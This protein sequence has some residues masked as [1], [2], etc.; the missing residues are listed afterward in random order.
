MTRPQSSL[1]PAARDAV[2]LTSSR[3]P[4][5]LCTPVRAGRGQPGPVAAREIGVPSVAGRGLPGNPRAHW[6]LPV[7]LPGKETAP[8]RAVV[9]TCWPVSGTP[10]P[11]R[12]ADSCQAVSDSRALPGLRHRVP[13]IR[14]FLTS[15]NGSAGPLEYHMASS[16][17]CRLVSISLA[18]PTWLPLRTSPSCPSASSPAVSRLLQTLARPSSPRLTSLFLLRSQR[19]A[20]DCISRQAPRPVA[21]RRP[22]IWRRRRRTGRGGFV[23]GGGGGGGDGGG[24]WRRGDPDGGRD[25]GW[26]AGCLLGEV[27]SFRSEPWDPAALRGRQPPAPLRH[28]QLRGDPRPAASP[29]LRVA[30]SLPSARKTSPAGRA[31]AVLSAGRHGRGARRGGNLV[32]GFHAA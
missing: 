7:S 20:P 32:R 22:R 11:G 3:L 4:T 19:R 15:R 25:R 13:V 9:L 26:V 16:T 1:W 30:R 21:N 8:A 2:A 5:S 18:G 27:C 23:R 24:S 28:Q 31:V 17:C 14:F 12:S 10:G 6:R 29:S